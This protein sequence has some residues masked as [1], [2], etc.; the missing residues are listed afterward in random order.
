MTESEVI[1]STPIEPSDPEYIGCFADMI[2]DRVM[3]TALTMVDLTSEV[4]LR[5]GL[6]AESSASKIL[7]CPF[8]PSLRGI[9]ASRTVIGL[10]AGESRSDYLL[11]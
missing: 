1:T 3:E 4:I 2:S 10:F 11:C 7:W 8:F 6:G 9:V 5:G